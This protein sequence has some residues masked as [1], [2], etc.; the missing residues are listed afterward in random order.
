[1]RVVRSIAA[2]LCLAAASARAEPRAT[3]RVSAV[4]VRSVTV[5]AQE[6]ARGPLLRLRT[7]AGETEWMVRRGPPEP[8]GAR[9]DACEGTPRCVMVT[10]HADAMPSPGE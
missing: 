10:L 4:V 6:T 8:G 9:A 2:V 7:A 1:V 3:L 5:S